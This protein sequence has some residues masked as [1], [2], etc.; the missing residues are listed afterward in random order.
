M[1]TSN[2]KFYYT[3][4]L[5]R[6]LGIL[7]RALQGSSDI[8]DLYFPHSSLN[9]LRDILLVKTILFMPYK[10][11]LYQHLFLWEVE[12]SDVPT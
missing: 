4:F 11:W 12:K 2:L 5:V 7:V 9:H 10:F 1:V 8:W 6:R 3:I